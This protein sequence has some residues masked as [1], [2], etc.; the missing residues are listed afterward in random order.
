MRSLSVCIV[1]F[2][3][4]LSGIAATYHVPDDFG[5][6]QGAI[7]DPGV[8]SG[9]VIIVRAGIYNEQLDFLGKA[10]TLTS[11][12]GAVNTFINGNQGG[13]TVSFKSWEG[14]DTI[15]EGFTI[16]NGLADRGGGIYCYVSS[17]TIRNNVIT[18]NESDYL[19]GG[20][21]CISC[22]P[23]INDNLIEKN[24]SY[25]GGGIGMD[26]YSSPII[27]NNTLQNNNADW[28]G[29]GCA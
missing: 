2:T 7:S 6:I 22:A 27:R 12:E 9:D 20:I 16:T 28:K 14:Y 15:L 21:C 24:D 17:P 19:G 10:I 25:H 13:S 4:S 26:R 1:F 29:G 8:V 11:D 5:T 18:Q 23:L 3:F